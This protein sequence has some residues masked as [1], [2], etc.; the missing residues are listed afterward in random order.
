MFQHKRSSHYRPTPT[1]PNQTPARGAGNAPARSP[2]PAPFATS[3]PHV[4]HRLAKKPSHTASSLDS[5]CYPPLTHSTHNYESRA[6]R[7]NS[8][9]VPRGETTPIP[10][11]QPSRVFYAATCITPAETPPTP[12]SPPTPPTP[13]TT[14]PECH[15]PHRNKLPSLPATRLQLP[16]GS[17][18][19]S[20]SLPPSA[21]HTPTLPKQAG[22]ASPTNS[23]VLFRRIVDCAAALRAR[24]T[25]PPSVAEGTVHTRGPPPSQAAQVSPEGLE[26][27]G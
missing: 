11:C 5:P 10:S 9:V 15:L 26:A 23:L 24:L 8:P 20:P 22:F 17:V 19:P 27:A 18:P 3:H 13:A 6:K 2:P 14:V 16:S 25:E 1:S 12:P 4:T 21:R 7:Q